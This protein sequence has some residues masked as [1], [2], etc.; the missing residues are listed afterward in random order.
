MRTLWHSR[1]DP[2]IRLVTGGLERYGKFARA[3]VE[4]VIRKVDERSLA[5]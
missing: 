2:A 1:M 4:V 5:K 3:T